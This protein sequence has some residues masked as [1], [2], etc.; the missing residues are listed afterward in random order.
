MAPEPLDLSL[1]IPVFD[2]AGFVAASVERLQ[3]WLAASGLSHEIVVVDDG[4]TDGT[5]VLIE[6]LAARDPA[7][8]LL[9]HPRN[10][11]KG[12]AVRAGLLAARGTARIFTDAD[13]AYP[14]ENLSAFVR[15]LRAGA[16]VVVANRE[17]PASRCE[18]ESGA[19]SG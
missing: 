18:M 17:D 5:P 14:P 13:L 16:A 7:L 11:G 4:S 12:A 1:V 10:V 15:E 19:R 2:G 8:R 3:A 6:A 9:R